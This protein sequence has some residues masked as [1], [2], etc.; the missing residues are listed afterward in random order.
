[1]GRNREIAELTII[2]N[3]WARKTP[4]LILEGCADHRI[5]T[6]AMPL[7]GRIFRTSRLR[8]G[9]PVRYIPNTEHLSTSIFAPPFN[10]LSTVF[11]S[12]GS[13]R[14]ATIP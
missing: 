2:S 3:W 10:E 14:A 1:M 9:D 12:P 5:L 6:V 4:W 7:Q 11:R 13:G 8:K